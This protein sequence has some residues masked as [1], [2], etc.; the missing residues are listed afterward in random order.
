MK[1]ETATV[2]MGNTFPAFILVRISF[3]LFT[4][5]TLHNSEVLRVLNTGVGSAVVPS[6]LTKYAVR[7]I[8]IVFH[9]HVFRGI[10]LLIR[11]LPF[12]LLNVQ[13]M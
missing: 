7:G 6:V 2:A 12:K 9:N 1:L 8:N 11:K 13:I 3:I 5:A 4:V 10:L